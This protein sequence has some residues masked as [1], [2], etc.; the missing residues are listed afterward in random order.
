MALKSYDNSVYFWW[1]IPLNYLATVEIANFW[2]QRDKVV[3]NVFLKKLLSCLKCFN[4]MWFALRVH[5]KEFD[6]KDAKW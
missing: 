5:I 3:V 4:L 2:N 6:L 1:I